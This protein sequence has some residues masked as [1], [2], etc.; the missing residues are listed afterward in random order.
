MTYP[1][2]ADKIETLVGA[3]RHQHRHIAR[4]ISLEQTVHILHSAECRTRYP[5]L[6]D[7]PYSIALDQG[8]DLTRWQGYL[9][10]PIV[11]TRRDG[12]LVPAPWDARGGRQ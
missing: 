1:V 5:D 12:E 8:I 7:C 3:K 2:P 6:R 11:V 4:A 10:R 9:D